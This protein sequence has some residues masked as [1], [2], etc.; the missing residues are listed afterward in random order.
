MTAPTQENLQQAKALIRDFVRSVATQE[1]IDEHA[2]RLL[3][4]PPERVEEIV[5]DI[6]EMIA[7][8]MRATN[9]QPS[10]SMIFSMPLAFVEIV[11][12]R[13]SEMAS[14]RGRA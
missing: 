12:E 6:R 8:G 2:F 3:G 9:P 13:A 4:E 10:S 14:N 5:A 11:K 7:D 1:L